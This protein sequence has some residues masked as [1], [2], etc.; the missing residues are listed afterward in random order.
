MLTVMHQEEVGRALGA[1]DYLIKPLEPRTLV[2]TLRR[3]V[4]DDVGRVL[5]VED[6]EP[7]RELMTRTL[8]TAGHVVT[9]A[10]NGQVAL[11]RLEAADPQVIVLDLMMPVMDGMMFLHH[12]RAMEAYANVPVIVATAQILTEADRRQLAATAQQV[13][14][15]KAHSRSELLT[16]IADEIRA[17]ITG[18]SAAQKA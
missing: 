8:R 14:E 13:I 16:I 6:D 2:E 1:V 11:D 17:R 4:H 10:E 9:E 18:E 15:K 3:Y 7:T 12:L 5:V